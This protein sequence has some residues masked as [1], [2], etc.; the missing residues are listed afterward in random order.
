MHPWLNFILHPVFSLP[1]PAQVT[2]VV[3]FHIG[4][5]TPNRING[6]F[7]SVR[8]PRY[9]PNPLVL[10]KKEL[11]GIH[12]WTFWELHNL[13]QQGANIFKKFF[14]IQKPTWKA[15][16]KKILINRFTG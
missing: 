12:T 14:L 16:G 8:K 15:Y 11:L 6:L 9:I 1:K 7:D 10:A 13:L 3:L 4:P 5:V 2:S